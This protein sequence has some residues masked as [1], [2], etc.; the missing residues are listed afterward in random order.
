MRNG[1]IWL[2]NF[3]PQVG[4]EIKKTRPVIIVNSDALGALPLKVVVPLTDG[5]KVQ[6]P[7]MAG[8]YP[9]TNNGI[10]KFSL[11]DCFQVK[12]ISEKRFIKKI[13]AL[14]EEEMAE[15]KIFLAKVLELF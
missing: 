8:I 4:H 3:E 11:A 13:G 9:N 14:S 5:A 10:S 7:W 2:V 15:V 1:E 6:Q 12:S